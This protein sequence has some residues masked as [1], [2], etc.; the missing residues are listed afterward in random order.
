[1]SEVIEGAS[2]PTPAIE[3]DTAAPVEAQAEEQVASAEEAPKEELKKRIRQVKV[4]F[5][6]KE[7]IEEL[8]FEI[9]DDPK[10]IEYMTKQI[11]M[12]KLAQSKS[13]EYSS[14]EK[15]VGAFLKQL[16]ENPR[17]ALANPNIGVDIKKLAAEIL[18]EE[19]TESNKTPEQIEKEK[20]ERELEEK[21]AEI[22]KKEQ[23]MKEREFQAMQEQALK[24]Y[25]TMISEAIQTSDLPKSPYVVKKMADMMIQMIKNDIDVDPKELVPVV[26]QEIMKDVQDMFGAMPAE[27][28]RQ[29][30]GKDVLGKLTK[31]NIAKV[32]QAKTPGTI[33]SQIKDIGTKKEAPKDEKK[34]SYKEFFGF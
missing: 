10:T 34:I 7:M 2:A 28:I 23:E 27:V 31:D 17:K 14:L 24:H 4:K 33:N 25:D 21:I 26:R 19:I 3:A 5:G 11:Q 9:D 18:E 22:E 13:Q 1:M 8:P 16:K 29:V 20:K 32:K 30:L 12:A 6:G 15:E